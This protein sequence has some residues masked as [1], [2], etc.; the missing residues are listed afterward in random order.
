MPFKVEDVKNAMMSLEYFRKYSLS[1]IH[2]RYSFPFL[3]G[4]YF[5]YRRIDVL[6]I[7]SVA[8]AISDNPS[9]LDV[10]C[11]YGDFLEKIR[12]YLPNAIGIEKNAEIFYSCKIPKPEFI[13]ISDAYW[14]ISEPYDI[15]FVG[16]MDPGVDF[17]DKVAA[18]TNVIITTLDQGLSLQA[19]YDAYG[20]ERIAVWRTPS[21][22]DVNTEIMNR[23]Y[24]KMLY[25]TRQDLFKLRSAHNLWYIYSKPD[26]SEAVKS[27]LLRCLEQENITS[28]KMHYEFESILDQCGFRYFEE[29]ENPTS[30]KELKGRLWEV[31]FT[32]S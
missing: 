9:Y 12:E 18:K 3:R 8:R 10:G 6:R 28:L 11:G 22:E 15:I 4:S 16:W 24:T 31:R 21:W 25:E 23:Y 5:V 17:R 14:G 30:E 2:E 7:A 1:H 29:L 13:E 27:A 32:K 19:E 20:F 26:K